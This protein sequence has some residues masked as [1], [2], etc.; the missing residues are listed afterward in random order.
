[1]IFLGDD[2]VDEDVENETDEDR[3]SSSEENIVA[4]DGKKWAYRFRHLE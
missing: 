4:S 3:G 1:M 2:S